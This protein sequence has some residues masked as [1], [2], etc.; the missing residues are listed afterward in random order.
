MSYLSEKISN[1]RKAAE[2]AFEVTLPVFAAILAGILTVV[3]TV[4]LA[5]VLTFILTSVLAMVLTE[6]LA[7]VH[8]IL[9]ASVC[10]LGTVNTQTVKCLLFEIYTFPKSFP[11]SGK[12]LIPSLPISRRWFSLSYSEASVSTPIVVFKLTAQTYVVKKISNDRKLV[13]DVVVL[14]LSLIALG[15]MFLLVDWC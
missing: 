7:L 4:V 15:L 1:D 6:A 8:A 9:T 3:L 12:P 10:V 5:M 11:T 14:R 13:D 2:A